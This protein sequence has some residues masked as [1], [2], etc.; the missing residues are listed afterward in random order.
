MNEILHIVLE[1]YEAVSWSAA[2][3]HLATELPLAA[4]TLD[5]SIKA[6]VGLARAP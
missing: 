6:R 3:G 4:A 5:L 1:M 2:Q